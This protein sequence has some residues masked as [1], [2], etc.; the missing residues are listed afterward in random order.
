MR[1]TLKILAVFL[2]MAA[3]TMGCADKSA[4]KEPTI[5]VSYPTQKYLTEKITGEGFNINTLIM[6]GINPENYDPSISSLV[7]LQNSK[8]YFR[9]N[10]PGFEE[11]ILTKIRS[12]YS[13][14]EIIDVSKGVSRIKGTHKLHKGEGD[15]HLFGSVKNMKQ[16]ASNIYSCILKI[17]GKNRSKYQHNY[18]ELQKS[19]EI[20]DD[21]ISSI[22]KDCKGSSFMVMHPSL[23][24]FARDYGLHQISIEDNGKEMTPKQ[25]GQRLNEAREH[26]VKV[27][28]YESEN[29]PAQAKLISE[30]LGIN[31]VKFSL[32][33]EDWSEQMLKI[34]NA[35]ADGCH[36]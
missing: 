22:L 1:N 24:Y 11:T 29:A 14:V 21:S 16:I 2:I 27:L 25:L 31:L 15:P 20:L 5:T 28:F 8:V 18:Q 6:P 10:T 34:A 19:L 7:A 26:G 13:D 33:S 3:L 35:I 32:V 23:S 9:M 4:Q 36:N 30:R 12:N 17:D